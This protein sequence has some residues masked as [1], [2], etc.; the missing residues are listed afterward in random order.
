[1][2]MCLSHVRKANLY[3]VDQLRYDSFSQKYQGTPGP[4]LNIFDG[5]FF[6]LVVL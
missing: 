1:M 2:K 4:V 3:Q 6:L 5:I